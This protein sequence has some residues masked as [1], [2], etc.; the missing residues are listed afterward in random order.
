ML[1]EV[2]TEQPILFAGIEILEQLVEFTAP[3]V[4][5]RRQQVA[6][7][8]RPLEVE[9]QAPFGD[10]FAALVAAGVFEVPRSLELAE[11]AVGEGEQEQAGVADRQLALDRAAVPRRVKDLDFQRAGP[12]REVESYN[13]V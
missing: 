5:G 2:I 11:L 12:L 1:Y 6:A 13:F 7:G 3:G 10:H 4:E 9:G 8:D